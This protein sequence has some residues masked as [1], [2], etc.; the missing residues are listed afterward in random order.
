MKF[1]WTTLVVVMLMLSATQVNAYSASETLAL[2]TTAS[3]TGGD[4]LGYRLEQLDIPFTVR[5]TA[6]V[7]SYV[8]RYLVE[9]YRDS[10]DILGRATLY[11]PIF[12]HYLELYGLPESLKFLPIVES[13][14][15][16]AVHSPAGAAGLWQFVPATARIYGLR[17]N[18]QVDERLDPHKSTEAAVRML[19]AL[20]EQFGDWGLVLAAYNCGPGRVKRIMRTYGAT[21]FWEAQPYLPQE[22]QKYIPRF[23][24]AAYMVNFHQS[25]GIS[26]DYLAPDLQ[27]T[28]TYR[29]FRPLH[30]STVARTLGV[31]YRTIQKLNPSYLQGLVP[32]H[33]QGQMVTVPERVATQFEA[34]FLADTRSAGPVNWQRNTYVTVPGDR[35][36]TLAQLFQCSKADLIRWNQLPDDKLTVNQPLTIY[37]PRTVVRP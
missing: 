36:G 28:H 17:V 29:I 18:G 8:R 3:N 9:G 31:S 11:F 10:E 21:D 7:R 26:P 27:L 25:H 34:A 30:L 1:P 2:A 14:L 5:N 35:L 13:A 6:R 37:L 32:E 4:D 19:S 33:P 15:K 23:I 20:Y 12:E 16:P 24:A 22:S